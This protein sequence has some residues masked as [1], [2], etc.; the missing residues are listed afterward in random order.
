MKL[1]YRAPSLSTLLGVTKAKK[2]LKR[3]L[4]ITALMRPLRAPENAKR[5]LLSRAGYYSEPMKL[6]RALLR[7]LR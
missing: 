3:E 4:G 7:A 1:R 6:I 5:R 2:R